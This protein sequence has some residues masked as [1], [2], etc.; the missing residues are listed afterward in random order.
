M[1]AERVHMI[2]NKLKTSVVVAFITILL[3]TAKTEERR[4]K[5]EIS[6]FT[7]SLAASHQPGS[8]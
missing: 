3:Y 8:W 7:F 4:Q 1:N 2:W 5:P 6:M